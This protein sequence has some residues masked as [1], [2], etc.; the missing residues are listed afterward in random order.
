M[1]ARMM[2]VKV[3]HRKVDDAAQVWRSLVLPDHR[4]RRGFRR[5]TLVADRASGTMVITTFWDNQADS[6]AQA[7]DPSRAGLTAQVRLFFDTPAT[8]QGYEVLVE[9]GAA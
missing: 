1:Y 2:T 3:D 9:G 8:T 5:A 6:D 4:R 7:R